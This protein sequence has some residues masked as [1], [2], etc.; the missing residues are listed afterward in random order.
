MRGGVAQDA[1]ELGPPAPKPEV[2]SGVVG[3]DKQ[4]LCAA[5][6][7]AR[8]EEVKSVVRPSLETAPATVMACGTRAPLRLRRSL[9][10]V[11]APS[12][13]D[14]VQIQSNNLQ[15][16]IRMALEPTHIGHVEEVQVCHVTVD[17]GTLLRIGRA[18]ALVEVVIVVTVNT[19][20]RNRAKLLRI[21]VPPLGVPLWV[22]LA[23]HATWVERVPDV[24][25]E[26]HI[27]ELVHLGQHRISNGL[28]TT[29]VKQVAV[30]LLVIPP[31]PQDEE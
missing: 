10:D 21:D 4:V 14:R 27:A 16:Q 31:I 12:A 17:L 1:Q 3:E 20:P 13:Q 30:I 5:A 25:Y 23:L 22:T 7:H 24:Y 11:W 29:S 2:I 9:I 28:L 26:F 15:V 8:L 19:V 18:S 6:C